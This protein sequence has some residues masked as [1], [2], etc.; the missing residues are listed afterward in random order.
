MLKRGRTPWH[1][2]SETDRLLARPHD[3][4]ASPAIAAASECWNDWRKPV[5]TAHDGRTRSEHSVIRRAIAEVQS[6]ISLRWVSPIGAPH[7][8]S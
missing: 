3:A 4:A 5:V 8:K 6:A 1:A 7:K 2:F